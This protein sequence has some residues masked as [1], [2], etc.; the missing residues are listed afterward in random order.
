[1]SE[2]NPNNMNEAL[3]RA[4]AQRCSRLRT[5][6]VDTSRLEKLL[7]GEIP[8]PAAEH[9]LRISPQIFRMAL[10]AVVLIGFALAAVMFG[11]GGE[12]LAAPAQMAQVHYDLIAG[13]MPA[14]Q[15]GSM[16]DLNK[17]VSAEAPTLPSI[18]TVPSQHLMTCCLHQVKDRKVAFVLLQQDG[19][20]VTLAVGR[21]TDL[22]MPKNSN[23]DH[24]T[25][26]EKLNMVMREQNGRFMCV[27]GE[28]PAEKLAS[29]LDSLK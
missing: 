12:A 1:M 3:D 5:M 20:P 18:P 8:R 9:A 22:K 29:L 10:A 26:Y 7:A 15:V 11:R 13:K 16:E 23:G 28:A 27:I 25:S 6:P 24:V 19:V 4:T 21:D 2:P 14:Q 17:F